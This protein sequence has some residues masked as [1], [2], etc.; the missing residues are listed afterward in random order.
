M[1]LTANWTVL[2]SHAQALLCVA[3]DPEVRLRDTAASRGVAERSAYGTVINL[4]EAGYVVNQK[5]GRRHRYQTQA[6]L[7]LPEPS[8]QER[9]AGTPWHLLP[10]PTRGCNGWPAGSERGS[11]PLPEVVRGMTFN[12]RRDTNRAVSRGVVKHQ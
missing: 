3:H 8:S 6:H 12:R 7:P 10:T 5:N 4:A 11:R 2:T 9:T 1:L